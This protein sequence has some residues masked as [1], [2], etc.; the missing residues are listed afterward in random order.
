VRRAALALLLLAAPQDAPRCDID[1]DEHV[2]L[3]PVSAR[4]APDGGWLV[5][6]HVWIYEPEHDSAVRNALLAAFA[7]ALDLP[8]GSADSALFRERAAPFIVD[9]ERGQCVPVDVGGA[10][11]E[12]GRSGADGHARAELLLPAEAGAAGAWLDASAR[13]RPGD[14]RVFAGRVRL[15]PAEGLTVV[16]DIDDTLRISDVRHPSALMRR[17]FLQPFEPVPGMAEVCAR[18]AEA[19]AAFEY[20]S[21]SPQQLAPALH[22]WLLAAGFPEGGLHLRPFRWK[23][24]R[25]FTL[26]ADPAEHKRPV[27]EALLAA[28]PQRRLVLVGDTG[29]DDPEIFGDFA[30]AHDGAVAA[31]LVRDTTGDGA[32]GERCAQ[33][34]RELPREVWQVF[35]EPAELDLASFAAPAGTESRTV[36]IDFKKASMIE[37]KRAAEAGDD[38]T[39]RAVIVGAVEMLRSLKDSAPA[40]AGIEQ[41][42]ED[43]DSLSLVMWGQMLPIVTSAAQATLD[44]RA[45]DDDALHI[46]RAF[47]D[48]V[49]LLPDAPAVD[50]RSG[51]DAGNRA[52][53]ERLV[54][55]LDGRMQDPRFRAGL[56]YTFDDGPFFPEIL[57]D[58]GELPATKSVDGPD[59]T[60]NIGDA[61]P[62]GGDGPQR[63][64][65]QG[66]RD[67]RVLWTAFL[68]KAPPGCDFVSLE[69]DPPWG[70]NLVLSFG[71]R[72]N[73]HLDPAGRPEYYFVSW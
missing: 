17:T 30:R 66:V 28:H 56:I 4:P 49:G 25:L 60:I 24:E 70:W 29:E 22:D 50:F 16:S 6:L 32:D 15:V 39:R 11:C 57:M 18:L 12:L 14:E 59:V 67:G 54:R 31:I 3:F 51:N 20:L 1:P 10:L 35:R 8:K 63:A 43:R 36:P 58:R 47:A 40:M 44:A 27:L 38:A 2:F 61:A 72:V 69:H 7:D 41:S 33:A 42:S 19:G 9:N 23:D 64:F 13:P 21:C 34:F 53:I 5:P 48:F 73:I 45:W 65:L 46:A 62:D 55:W 68:P 71:E 52:E 26:F 37:L